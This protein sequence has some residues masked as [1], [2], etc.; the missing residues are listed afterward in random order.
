[1][2]KILSMLL[3]AAMV[4]CLAAP[5]YAGTAGEN[6]KGG[7]KT[8]GMSPMQ[9]SDG[10]KEGWDAAKFKPLGAVGGLLKGVFYM[11][12]DIVT[13]AW[14]VLTCWTDKV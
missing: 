9:V 2:K 8:I 12:K 7:F 10:V 5:V 14:D 11:G 1:M 3:V 6:L 13:G 4:A